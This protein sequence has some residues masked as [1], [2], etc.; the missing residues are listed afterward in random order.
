MYGGVLDA[1]ISGEDFRKIGRADQQRLIRTIRKKLTISPAQFGNPLAGD[2]KGFWKLKV[3]EFRVVYQ[4]REDHVEV[5][6]I[7]I[8]YRRNEE[9]YL[10]AAKRLKLI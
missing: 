8:G 3:A 4:I 7:S 10:T 5:Y 1:K 9:A 6:V 2:L